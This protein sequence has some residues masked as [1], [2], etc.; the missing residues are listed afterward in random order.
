VSEEEEAETSSGCAGAVV[1][2]VLVT[3]AVLGLY[4]ASRTAFILLIWALGWGAVIWVAKQAPKSV[5]GAANP[6]PPAPSERGSEKKPQVTVIRDRSRPNRW[7]VADPSP[8]MDWE[9]D[10]EAGTT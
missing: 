1:L 3:G 7:A 4:A 6:A 10:K 5:R 9:P 8:W 2:S